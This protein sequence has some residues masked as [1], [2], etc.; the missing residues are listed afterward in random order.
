[1][2][3]F[4]GGVKNLK[5]FLVKNLTWPDPEMDVQGEVLSSFIVWGRW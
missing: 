1:M 5:T 2:P 4:A 3:E